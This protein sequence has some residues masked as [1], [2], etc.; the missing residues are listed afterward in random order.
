MH[1]SIQGEI[2]ANAKAKVQASKKGTAM[3]T[4]PTPTTSIVE[5]DQLSRQIARE[6][7]HFLAKIDQ[8]VIVQEIASAARSLDY[9]NHIELKVN[10]GTVMYSTLAL[11]HELTDIW[12]LDAKLQDEVWTAPLKWA[13]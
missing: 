7:N 8:Q 11:E 10:R 13:R 6:S 4:L 5:L 12:K 1:S 3:E 9:I 2:K